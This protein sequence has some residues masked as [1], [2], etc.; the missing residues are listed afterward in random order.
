MKEY[1]DK[2]LT[3]NKYLV[4]ANFMIGYDNKIKALKENNYWF[5]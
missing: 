1:L 2:N 3:C 5:I 4:H